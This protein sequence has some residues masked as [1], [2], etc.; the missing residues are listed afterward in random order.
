MVLPLDADRGCA[1]ASQME[2]V[3][4]AFSLIWVVQVHCLRARCCLVD[5]DIH[6]GVLIQVFVFPG[7]LFFNLDMVPVLC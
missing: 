4:A 2:G 1:E 6:F 5:I 3:Q 7:S